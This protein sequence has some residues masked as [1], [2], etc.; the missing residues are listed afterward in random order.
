MTTL[1]IL[2]VPVAFAHAVRATLK[3]PYRGTA[4]RPLAVSDP[5]AF[6]CR[7]CLRD[8]AVGEHVL[9]VSYC[10][11]QGNSP[12]RSESA[13][14]LHAEPCPPPIDPRVLPEQLRR[15]LLSVRSFDEQELLVEA[16]IVEGEQLLTL[17][18]A[19]FSR[20]EVRVVYAYVARPGCFAARLE[21]RV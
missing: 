7:A 18:A 3:D 8:A 4:L 1:H 2:P 17:A 5:H 6:P 20:P 10:P 11:F 19:L 16:D 9:L 12:F 13:I 14:Y 21:S 15:R